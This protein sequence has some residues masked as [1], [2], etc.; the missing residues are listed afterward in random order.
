M[1]ARGISTQALESFTRAVEMA[2][3]TAETGHPTP[4]VIAKLLRGMVRLYDSLTGTTE[5][6]AIRVRALVV[7]ERLERQAARATAPTLASPP[8]NHAWTCTCGCRRG[9]AM[10]EDAKDVPHSHAAPLAGEELE[11]ARRASL[12]SDDAYRTGELGALNLDDWTVYQRYWHAVGD[13]LVTAAGAGGFV[14]AAD[15]SNE[16][17]RRLSPY[18]ENVLAF[19]AT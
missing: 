1:D 12:A 18:A 9:F 6:D 8:A 3:Q 5:T 17:R 13:E 10:N 15:V 11:A 16:V 4:E 7:A 14:S 2:E 19:R